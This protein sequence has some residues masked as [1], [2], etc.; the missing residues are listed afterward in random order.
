MASKVSGDHPVGCA[1]GSHRRLCR[2]GSY[3]RLCLRSQG[4]TAGCASVTLSGCAGRPVDVKLVAGDVKPV[5]CLA[6]GEALAKLL[7]SEGFTRSDLAYGETL[8]KILRPDEFTRSDL[9]Q[10]IRCSVRGVAWADVVDDVDVA[11]P[12]VV[13]TQ[14]FVKTPT[15]KTVTVDVD[16][17]GVVADAK[18]AV[19]AK[20]GIPVKHQRL[21]FL[22]QAA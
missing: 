1:A 5:G 16:V 3:G 2:C 20:T 8:A 22:R 19:E 4:V 17:A 18:L 9:W 13:F 11:L 7:R 6:C 14:V 10:S 12:A 15:G 21:L